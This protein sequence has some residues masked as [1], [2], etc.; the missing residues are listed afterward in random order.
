MRVALA[1]LAACG[2]TSTPARVSNRSAVMRPC[3]IRGMVIDAKTGKPVVDA[4]VVLDGG[5]GDEVAITDRTG[6]FDLRP[7]RNHESLTVFF[8][9]DQT[10]TA[11]LGAN[12]CDEI[13][14]IR[15]VVR[16][17]VESTVI[18]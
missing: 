17:W 4:A 1:V 5:L 6:M 15:L 14:V 12:A 16:S 18:I 11:K 3:H 2:A 10:T 13:M 7:L 8:V 9:N